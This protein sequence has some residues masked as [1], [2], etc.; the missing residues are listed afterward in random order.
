MELYGCWRSF[1]SDCVVHGLMLMTPVMMAYGMSLREIRA[2]L[3]IVD[4][5]FLTRHFTI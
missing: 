5:R 2:L 1:E 4:V 3:V